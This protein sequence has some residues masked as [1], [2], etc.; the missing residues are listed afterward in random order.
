VAQDQPVAA[1]GGRDYGRWHVLWGQVPP[2]P[3]T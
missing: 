1:G 3:E 2:W